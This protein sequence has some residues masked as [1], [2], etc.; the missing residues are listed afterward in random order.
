[1]TYQSVVT[2]DGSLTYLNTAVGATYRSVNGAASESRHVFLESSSLLQRPSPWRVLELGFGTGLNFQTTSRAA[3]EA[4]V[5]LDYVTLEPAL[6]PSDLWL[7]ETEWKQARPGHPLE[8]GPISLTIVPLRWQDYAPATEFFDACYHDPFGP[9]QAPECWEAPCFEWSAQ[10]LKTDGVLV[11][12][13]AAGATRRA[14]QLAGYQVGILPGANGKREMTIASRSASA[15]IH[16][17][18][19]KRGHSQ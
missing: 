12:F 5:E 15:L 2:R 17:R 7:T 8:I 4:G 18:R 19:W 14:M 10:A 1:M 9:G 13:G 6:M 11:T 16:A 3:Q